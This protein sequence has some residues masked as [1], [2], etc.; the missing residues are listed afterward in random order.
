MVERGLQVKILG[1]LLA[2]F[3]VFF[4]PFGLPIMLGVVMVKLAYKFFCWIG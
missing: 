3:I 2:C 4:V 1:F